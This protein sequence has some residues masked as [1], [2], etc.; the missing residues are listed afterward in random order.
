MSTLS[1]THN[2]HRSTEP[3]YCDE[4]WYPDEVRVCLDEF[5]FA[6]GITIISGP[7]DTDWWAVVDFST[8]KIDRFEDDNHKHVIV[9]VWFWAPVEAYL[10]TTDGQKTLQHYTD[11]A[12]EEHEREKG[13]F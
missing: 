3:D 8:K 1:A 13:G 11:L 2:Y 4:P 9:P 5:S 7:V 12:R 10:Q 6:E